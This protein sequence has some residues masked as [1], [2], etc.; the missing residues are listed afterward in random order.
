[1][2]SQTANVICVV[3]YYGFDSFHCGP[4][5]LSGLGLRL[6]ANALYHDFPMLISRPNID[7]IDLIKN[8]SLLVSVFLC[9]SRVCLFMVQV[10]HPLYALIFGS[11]LLSD[12]NY[13]L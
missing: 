1:M 7:L 9:S 8:F 2:R 3:V 6:Y 5:R 13:A 11:F 4:L 12:K 10:K